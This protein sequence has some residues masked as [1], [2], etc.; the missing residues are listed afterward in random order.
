LLVVAVAVVVPDQ[1]VPAINTVL[2]VAAAVQLAF[3]GF[4]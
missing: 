1:K 3:S 2:V 4:M